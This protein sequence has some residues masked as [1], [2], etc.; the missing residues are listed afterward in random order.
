MC[1]SKELKDFKGDV[2]ILS[3][4]V[5]LITKQTLK[6]LFRVHLSGKIH[7]VLSLVTV[8]LEDPSGYGRV[9]RDGQGAVKRVVEDKD[10]KAAEK[11]INEVNSGIYLASSTFLLENLK[12]ISRKN[13]QGE[14]YL[15][16]LVA[17]A[18]GRGKR[19]SAL[20]HFDPNEVM[21]INNRIELARAASVM[22]KKIN[23]ELMLGGVTIIDPEATYIDYGVRVGKDT[24]IHPNVH[25]LGPTVIGT[26]CTV[27]EGVRIADSTI[28]N[29]STI[30][31]FSVIES[32]KIGKTVSIG[33]FARLRPENTIGDGARVGNFV[34]VKKTLLGKGS[35]ANHLT[36]LG[37]SVIGKDVN[38]GAGTITCNYDGIKK[39]V[40]HIKDG[41]FIGSD[42]QLI[43]PITVGKNAYIGSGSTITKDVPPGSLALSRP[44]QK[45]IKEWVKKRGLKKKR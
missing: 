39:Y 24:T 7:P 5:P 36:Y 32:S 17:L 14:Y 15:P 25:L 42:T 11:S 1:A 44:E 4:D 20:T 12:R 30:R 18:T 23:T 28:G 21:G 2:L 13:V 33:P 16:D 43:A 41:A 8:L 37:D 31:S 9:I 34:E 22:R 19:V 35:K 38:I 26:G 29:S 6:A 10:L 40:T 27:E 45:V 3:G